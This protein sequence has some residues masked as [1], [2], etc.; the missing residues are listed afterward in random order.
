MPKRTAP[1]DDVPGNMVLFPIL[2]FYPEEKSAMPKETKH[3]CKWDK[4]E[5]KDNLEKLKGI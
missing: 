5:I 1:P 4:E 2:L 3:L